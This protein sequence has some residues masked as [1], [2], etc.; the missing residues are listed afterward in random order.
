MALSC[1]GGGRPGP[2]D[3]SAVNEPL[4]G[5]LVRGLRL[6]VPAGRLVQG[7]RTGLVQEG[8]PPNGLE[9]DFQV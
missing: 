5:A 7:G 9:P 8:S 6:L 2:A 1:R 3:A 4:K